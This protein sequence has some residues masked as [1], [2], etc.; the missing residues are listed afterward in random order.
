MLFC[1]RPLEAD[2]REKGLTSRVITTAVFSVSRLASGKPGHSTAWPRSLPN[3]AQK[4]SE[5][6]IWPWRSLPRRRGQYKR[7]S[8]K[9]GRETSFSLIRPCDK[10]LLYTCPAGRRSLSHS[11]HIGPIRRQQ[12][13]RR[14]DKK[15]VTEGMPRRRRSPAPGPF[16]ANPSRWHAVATISVA[17]TSAKYAG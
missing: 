10:L 5:H 1:Y 15:G 11:T 4:T 14:Q 7:N 16:F 17:I 12:I 8:A 9:S 6:N 2:S 3:R 13:G